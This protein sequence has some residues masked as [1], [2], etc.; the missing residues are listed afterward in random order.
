MLTDTKSVDIW[1]IQLINRS[2]SCDDRQLD[3]KKLSKSGIGDRVL[4]KA[5]TIPT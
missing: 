4:T 1:R 2:Q 5:G 3:L